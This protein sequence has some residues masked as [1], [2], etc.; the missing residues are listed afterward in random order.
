ML[1]DREKETERKRERARYRRLCM[2]SRA[3]EHGVVVKH[4]APS[5]GI[6]IHVLL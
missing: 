3:G 5:S 1:R 2:H 6:L 4:E